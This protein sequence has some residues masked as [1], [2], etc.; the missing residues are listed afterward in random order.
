MTVAST[1]VLGIILRIDNKAHGY[2]PVQCN[3]T[4]CINLTT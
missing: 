1:I 2:I 4:V 3:Y